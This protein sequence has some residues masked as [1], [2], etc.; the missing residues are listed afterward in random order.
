EDRVVDMQVATEEACHGRPGQVILRGT[1]PARAQHRPGPDQGALDSIP[2]RPD[3]VP[4]RHMTGDAEPFGRQ[5][6]A[7]PGPIRVESFAEDQL[8]TDRD[9]LER[10][11]GNAHPASRTIE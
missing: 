8:V 10:R 3:V 5:P 2:D 6:P 9:E 7:E 4:N 1:E 11:R